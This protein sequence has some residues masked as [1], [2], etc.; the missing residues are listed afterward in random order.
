MC[1]SIQDLMAF[2]QVVFD[3]VQNYLRENNG[4][5]PEDA[6]IYVDDDMQVSVVGVAE[7]ANS[8]RFFWVSSL[9]REEDGE[10]IPDC[11]NIHDI[12]SSF[13]FVR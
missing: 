13:F 5:L 6:G 11:D 9:V 8:D 10:L 12:A 4:N 1:D 7:A 3:E 2:S